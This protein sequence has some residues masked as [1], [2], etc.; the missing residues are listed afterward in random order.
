MCGHYLRPLSPRLIL[1]VRRTTRNKFPRYNPEKR[2]STSILY[3]PGDMLR[4]VEVVTLLFLA[5]MGFS[6]S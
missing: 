5:K 2:V 3:G 4:E 1:N 6:E